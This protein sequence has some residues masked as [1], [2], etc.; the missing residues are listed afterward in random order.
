[1]YEENRRRL[2]D[3]LLMN[4]EYREEVELIINREIEKTLEAIVIHPC[5][6][7]INGEWEANWDDY[8]PDDEELTV[9][10]IIQSF[11]LHNQLDKLVCHM[12]KMKVILEQMAEYRWY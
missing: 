2:I 1:M 5:A 8:D 3:L 6:I 10:E 11:E 4:R 7:C 9:D 12:N